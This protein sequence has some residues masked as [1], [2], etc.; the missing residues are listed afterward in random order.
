MIGPALLRAQLQDLADHG[1]AGYTLSEM[2]AYIDENS[3]PA[4]PPPEFR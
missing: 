3:P 1:F 2:I 4:S